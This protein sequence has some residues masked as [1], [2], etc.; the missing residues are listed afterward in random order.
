LSLEDMNMAANKD[1]FLPHAPRASSPGWTRRSRAIAV[2][3]AVAIA[4]AGWAAIT[5]LLHR[6]PVPLLA[7]DVPIDKLPDELEALPADARADLIARERARLAADPMDQ[8]ALIN[9]SLLYGAEGDRERANA[10]A[11]AAAARALRD[12]RAQTAAL[13]IH[14]QKGDAA[15]ALVSLDALIRTR[16]DSRDSLFAALLELAG[17]TQA[18]VPVAKLLAEEPPWRGSFFA[19]AAEKSERPEIAYQ[20]L[21]ALKGS[22]APPSDKEV[23]V[24]VRRYLDAK[25]Y[26]T[27]YFIW[28][29]ALSET[30]LRKAANVFDGGFDLPLADLYFGWTRSY[31]NGVETKIV[32]RANGSSDSVLR[33]DF[34]GNRDRVGP[35]YQF[36]RLVPGRYILSGD[37]RSERLQ[38]ETGLVWRIICNEG[39]GQALAETPAL[40][41]DRQWDR[42]EE[43]FEVPSGCTTQSLGLTGRSSAVLDQQMSG[44]AY[45]DN[46]A[47]APLATG[48]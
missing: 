18:A 5:T 3:A 43:R 32:P 7:G 11:I 48:Q 12:G 21:S 15:A 41:G 45:Y 37:F 2:L 17:N 33:I 34:V 6:D 10:F 8:G 14:L 23:Q 24:L 30:A 28:L 16:P 39:G 19:W 40:L 9:L 47:I 44:R 13:Q 1:D 46:M 22:A 26:S 31:S 27:A 4:C 20:L 35:V 29:D 25:D 36:L 42:F 38:T